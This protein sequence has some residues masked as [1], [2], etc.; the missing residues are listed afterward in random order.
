MPKFLEDEKACASA[1]S[2]PSRPARASFLPLMHGDQQGHD[3]Q[4]TARTRGDTPP[5]PTSYPKALD[6]W[7]R[8]LKETYRTKFPA[9]NPPDLLKKMKA[10]SRAGSAGLVKA[11]YKRR[12]AKLRSARPPA[13]GR[14]QEKQLEEGPRKKRRRRRWNAIRVVDSRVPDPVAAAGERRVTPPTRR[15]GPGESA[16]ALGTGCTGRTPAGSSSPIQALRLRAALASKR[17]KR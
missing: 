7:S 1:S 16:G 8:D 17:S 2:N 6:M 11:D 10:D 9:L 14:R 3:C 15:P 5:A 12:S 13:P 4:V